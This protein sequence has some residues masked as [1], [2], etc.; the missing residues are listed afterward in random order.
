MTQWSATAIPST[1][2]FNNPSTTLA[3]FPKNV[4][5]LAKK[6]GENKPI[7]PWPKVSIYIY[8]MHALIS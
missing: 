6:K 4:A 1:A 3:P 7:T 2:C 8:A 5:T